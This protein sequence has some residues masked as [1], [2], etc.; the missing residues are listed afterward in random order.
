MKFMDKMKIME[1]IENNV[2]EFVKAH[3]STTHHEVA[4]A[5]NVDEL[6]ALHELN[7][8]HKKGL[9]QMQ[10]IPLDETRDCSHYYYV[11]EK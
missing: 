1:T 11:P 3:P 9:I 2:Y 10:I 4:K 6:S 7:K 5:L 8:L